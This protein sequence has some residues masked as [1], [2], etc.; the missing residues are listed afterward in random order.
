MPISEHARTILTA[1]SPRLAIRILLITLTPRNFDTQTVKLYHAPLMTEQAVI[2]CLE[3]T[4]KS[5]EIHG[6]IRQLQ[7]PRLGDV[8]S[9]G[10]GELTF[11]LTGE[12][13]DE[14][15]PL[16]RLRI[17]GCLK[18][19]C[20]RCLEPIDYPLDIYVSYVVIPSEGLLPLPNDEND[21]T[22][23]LVADEHIQ[24]QQLVE[25]EVLLGLPLA[26]THETPQCGSVLLH[27][28]AQKDAPFDILKGWKLK[29]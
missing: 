15:H 12:V 28:T 10:D 23:Y 22:D 19:V 3:F 17:T 16:L 4:R 9:S 7:L 25:D 27:G 26:L 1:I 11:R 13:N 6:S 8:S 5:L 14:G 29:S 24:I 21:E 18:L 2:N 20:Q